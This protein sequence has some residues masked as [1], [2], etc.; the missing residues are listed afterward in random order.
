MV[1]Y[2]MYNLSVVWCNV[3]LYFS[4]KCCLS[5][6]RI[7]KNTCKYFVISGDRQ[8]IF[9]SDAKPFDRIRSNFAHEMTLHIVGIYA[10]YRDVSEGTQSD[11]YKPLPHIFSFSP[12]K[13]SLGFEVGPLPL[14]T[15]TYLLPVLS[16]RYDRYRSLG[17]SNSAFR[18]RI[19]S[20][21]HGYWQS[22]SLII[23]HGG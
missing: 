20:C 21:M 6:S 1:W 11:M 19:I 4:K 5:W 14:S 16:R 23:K 7:N 3:K 22:N 18:G 2:G 15:L 13:S 17:V 9:W 12:S 8:K 10:K